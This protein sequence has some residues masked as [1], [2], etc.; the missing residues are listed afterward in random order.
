MAR[1]IQIKKTTK[2]KPQ[3]EPDTRTPS[4][5]PLPY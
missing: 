2:P 4:G 5:T 1:Q 3:E